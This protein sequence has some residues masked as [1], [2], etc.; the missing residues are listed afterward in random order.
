MISLS[1]NIW[2]ILGP[3]NFLIILICI[4][5]CLKLFKKKF[6]SNFFLILSLIY[7]C[8]I[9]VFPTGY[10]FLNKL[11]SSF[12]SKKIL[13]SNIDGLLILGGPSSSNLSSVH[14]QVS[15]N[16]AGERLTESV[17]VIKNFKPKK[18]IFSG[19]SP[20]QTFDSSHAYVAEKFFSEM[21]IETDNIIFEFKS[22]NTYENI[23][24]SME[25]AQPKKE[26]NWLIITSSFHMKRAIYIAEKLDWKFIPYPVDFRTGLLPYT[27]PSITFLRNINAFDLASHEII[28]LISYYFLGRTDKIF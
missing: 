9:A 20:S 21:G 14:Q 23:L 22:R 7:F 17:K 13:E 4:G 1:K 18:I 5:L 24:F 16:E 2:L 6:S 15:F 11:E 27:K 19:G 25:I 8:I 12:Q 10:Y 28:G 26:E 3:I